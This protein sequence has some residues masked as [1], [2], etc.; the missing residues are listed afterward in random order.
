VSSSAGMPEWWIQL[1]HPDAGAPDTGSK[2]PGTGGTAAAAQQTLL[3][4]LMTYFWANALGGPAE[5]L[6]GG[7]FFGSKQQADFHL[8][9]PWLQVGYVVLGLIMVG[10][11]QGILRLEAW[12]YWAAWV[13]VLGLGAVTVTEIYKWATGAPVTLAVFIF[14]CM[15]ALFVLLNIYFGLQ[16]G[17]RTTLRYAPYKSGHFSPPL[18][19]FA[20]VLVVPAL[21][22]SVEVNHVDKHLSTPVLGLV[23][24]LGLALMILMGYGALRLQAWVWAAAWAWTA[25]LTVLSVDVIVLRLTGNGVSVQGLIVAIVNLLVVT[26]FVYYLQR[27]DVRRAFLHAR[28]RQALFSPPMLMGGLALAVFALVIY[29]LPGE[30]GTAAI[31]YT[32]LGLAVGTIVGLLDGVD[33][34]A[35]LM[36]FILGLLLAFA[37]YLVRGGLLPYTKVWSAVVVLL[38][39]AVITGVTALFRSGAW[40]A[41]M[42]LGAGTLY[43]VVELSFQVAPSAYLATAGLAL[44]SILFSFGL[45][46]MVSAVLG[47][48]LVPVAKA[49]AAPADAAVAAQAAG[50]PGGTA[51]GGAAAGTGTAAQAPAG[52]HAQ[53]TPTDAKEPDAQGPHRAPPEGEAR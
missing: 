12:V 52:R 24:V 19:I 42:L 9:L 39:L 33:P 20:V 27:A 49:A 13:L 51:A 26:N 48:K 44:L 37:S 47:L 45:G 21:A 30:L 11:A 29:L 28:A 31:A 46:Y 5:V 7:Y 32:V 43:G 6:F 53:G 1:S 4:S 2:P 23:Y 8:S 38:L 18:T 22:I 10:I 50:P 36:G 25:I 3:L 40:F 14:A 34:V 41:S 35:R 16:P 15:N 17:V